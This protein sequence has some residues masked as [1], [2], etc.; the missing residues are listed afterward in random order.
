MDT[1]LHIL[2]GPT[3]SGKGQVAR[4]IAPDLGMEIVVV[5]SM[6]IFRGMDILTAKPTPE[7]R[8]VTPHHLVDI[9]DPHQPFSVADWLPLC[10]KVIQD[11]PSPLLVSGTPLYLNALLQGLFPGP[12][13]RWDLR[14]AW[15]GEDPAILHD[16]L[17]EVDPEAANRIHPND[18]RRVMRALEVYEETG[19]P[20][21]ELQ[22]EQTRKGRYRT[23][24]VGILWERKVLHERIEM[25]ARMMFERGLVDE[26]RRLAGEPLS[27]QAAQAVGYKEVLE[28]VRGEISEEEALEKVI[29]QTRRLARHQMTWFRK[30]PSVKWIPASWETYPDPIAKEVRR[31]ITGPLENQGS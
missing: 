13:A 3:A 9:A 23:R 4:S 2:L 16:R 7:Q 15:K 11:V 6:K 29:I 22:R 8:A 24:I 25:R 17:R 28:H 18:V 31:A 12:P 19:K 10:E 1:P 20:I 26:V 5:D 27:R 30:F 21:S 14:E